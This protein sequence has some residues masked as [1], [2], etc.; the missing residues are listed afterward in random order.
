VQAAYNL[1]KNDNKLQLRSW[2]AG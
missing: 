1:K 2:L